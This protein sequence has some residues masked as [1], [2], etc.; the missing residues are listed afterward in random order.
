MTSK[1]N[2][3]PFIKATNVSDAIRVFWIYNFYGNAREPL[4]GY[5]RRNY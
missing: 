5:V 2:A 4:L 3:G 1:L